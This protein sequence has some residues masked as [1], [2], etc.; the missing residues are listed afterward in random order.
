MPGN[1]SRRTGLV[2]S[3]VAALGFSTSGPAVKPLLEAGWTPGGAMLV[4]LSLGSLLLAGP[5]LWAL[6]GRYHVLRD[7]WRALLVFGVLSVG[8]GSTMYYLA[9]D[10]LPIAVALLVE[11]TAP[12][13]LLALAWVRTRRR[14][15]GAVLAG[16]ALA[17]GGLVLV[18]DVAGKVHLDPVGLLFASIAAIGNASYWAVAAKP[19]AVP[20]VTLAGAGMVIGAATVGLLGLTGLLPFAMPAVQ[21]VV[22]GAHLSWLVPVLVVGIL[23]TALSFGISAVA[24]RMLGERVASFVALAEVLFAVVLAWL[25]LGQAPLPVQILGAAFVVGG[26][27]LVRHGSGIGAH[28]VGLTRPAVVEAFDGDATAGATRDATADVTGDASGDAPADLLT[29]DRISA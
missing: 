26:V 14:P 5:A 23:P 6:H 18:L 17:A 27:T 9:V 13:L 4:R 16:A 15:S 21:V 12:L 19:L 25:L 11:Y 20:P 28:G 22:L 1:G 7:E 29:L 8:C 24:V 10:R 2:V 3:L